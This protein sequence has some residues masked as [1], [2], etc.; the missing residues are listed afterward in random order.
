MPLSFLKVSK[1]AIFDDF[2]LFKTC[3][4]V[5]QI[6]KIY[7]DSILV[8]NSTLPNISKHFCTYKYY[9]HSPKS[10]KQAFWI[11][12]AYFQAQFSKCVRTLSWYVILVS[13][14]FSY[15]YKTLSLFKVS[16]MAI[17]SHLQL[18][19]AYFQVPKIFKMCLDTMMVCNSTLP[20][21]FLYFYTYIRHCHSSMSQKWLF[22]AIYSYF[23]PVFRYLKFS[24]CVWTLSWY[25]ILLSQTFSYIFI[26]I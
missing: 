9:S 26:L 7:L 19:L 3:F 21:I 14:T 1:I 18:F 4:W 17:F 15:L 13:Q 16:K 8:W 12:L 2:G 20:N 10:Q 6:F 25:V 11:L 23:Q 22:L 24:K 5:P